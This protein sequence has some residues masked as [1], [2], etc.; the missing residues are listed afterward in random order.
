MTHAPGPEWTPARFA[1]SIERVDQQQPVVWLIG[2]LDMSTVPA[3]RRILDTVPGPVMLEC[4]DL[5]FIDSSG[6]A[7]LVEAHRQRHGEL[8]LHN[9]RPFAREL[10]EMTGLAP[11]LGMDRDPGEPVS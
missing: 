10:I 11:V 6:L 2:E 3:L 1:A 8:V 4:G 5:E 7:A 9:L